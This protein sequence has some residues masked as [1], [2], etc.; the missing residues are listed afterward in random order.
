MFLG[1]VGENRATLRKT[2]FE[3]IV[4]KGENAGNQHF[5]LCPLCILT[6]QNG[7]QHF[8]LFPK[9]LKAFNFWVIESGKWK[10]TINPFPK[11]PWFLHVCST[12]L[13]NTLWEKEKLLIKS[14]FSFFH[15]VFY[16]FG[17][18]STIFIKK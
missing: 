15:S 7:Y 3:N 14:N 18:L 11:K 2:P 1:K 12:S 17:E 16:L 6:Q 8:L 10:S 13:L 9:F 4:V 5:H